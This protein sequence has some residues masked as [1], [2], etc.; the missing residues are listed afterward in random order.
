[1]KLFIPMK[2]YR[3][4]T[5]QDGSGDIE[6]DKESGVI[7]VVLVYDD[8]DKARESHDED[9]PIFLLDATEE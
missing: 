1:M 4:L 3:Q 6:I 5:L 8:I 2:V 7:G 9:V